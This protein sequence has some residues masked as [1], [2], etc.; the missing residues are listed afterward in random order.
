M[1]IDYTVWLPST[2]NLKVENKFGDIFIGD[3]KGEV[4]IDLSNGNLKSHDFENKLSLVL[5]FADATVN[6]IG[7]AQI[8]CNYSDLYIKKAEMLRLNSKSSN[9]EIAELN[10]LNADSRR[11]K[12]RIRQADLYRCQRQFLQLQNQ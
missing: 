11:D 4:E 1:Q 7:T 12:F 10:D 9:F 2:N 8:E 5:N 3:F 6:Q